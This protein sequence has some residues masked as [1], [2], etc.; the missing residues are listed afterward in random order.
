MLHAHP[1]NNAF[2]EVDPERWLA[3]SSPLYGIGQATVKSTSAASSQGVA[4][5][6]DV[7]IQRSATESHLRSTLILM[8]LSVHWWFPS[9]VERV[10]S[11]QDVV[12]VNNMLP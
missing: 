9:R 11:L 2:S 10:G 7:A 1:R 4:H 12:I 6:H 8:I 5:E 3:D